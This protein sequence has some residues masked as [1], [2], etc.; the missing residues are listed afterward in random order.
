MKLIV[1]L[2]N[3]GE[4]YRFT[5]HNLGFLV[6]DEL[7]LRHRLE[8][9]RK[10]L[11]SGHLAKGVIAQESVALLKPQTYMNL[12]GEAVRGAA[13]ELNIDL[14]HILV[15]V[16]DVAI[17]YG[18]LR[19]RIDSGSGG[20]NGLKSIEAHLQSTHYGRL[21]VGI[22]DRGEGED[23]AEHVLSPFSEEEKKEL[24]ELIQRA[25]DAVEI[26]IARG[27]NAMHTVH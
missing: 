2:G 16:D 7:A 21:R 23:L 26:W 14:G 19:F 25:A 13:K 18:R 5:R 24:P 10:R 9:K 15:V 3:P 17:P 22:G 6:L 1:G 27:N 20:H 8:F 12:S 4:E 11:Y